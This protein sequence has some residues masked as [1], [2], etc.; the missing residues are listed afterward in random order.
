[1]DC[2]IEE[3]CDFI[4]SKSVIS[5]VLLEGYGL[6]CCHVLKQPFV[7]SYCC[8]NW[9]QL[10]EELSV[11]IFEEPDMIKE[12]CKE[13]PSWPQKVLAAY[14]CSPRW[15]PPLLLLILVEKEPSK[16]RTY[17][18]GKALTQGGKFYGPIDLTVLGRGQPVRCSNVHGVSSKTGT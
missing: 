6:P 14:H 7:D 15:S 16:W 8:L 11:V 10:V 17:R 5:T 18:H 1:M 13:N 9:V 12:E 3:V 2:N 4:Y